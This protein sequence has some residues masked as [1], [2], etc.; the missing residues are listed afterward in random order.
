[1]HVTYSKHIVI[2]RFGWQY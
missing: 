2:K 1:M